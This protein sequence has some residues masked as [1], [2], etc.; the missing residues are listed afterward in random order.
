M[1]APEHAD[2][3]EVPSHPTHCVECPSAAEFACGARCQTGTC[4]QIAQ[5]CEFGG[6]SI[7]YAVGDCTPDGHGGCQR[8]T[9]DSPSARCSA[10][11]LDRARGVFALDER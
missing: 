6:H 5:E 9:S 8:S 7:Q 3:H 4:C 10:T 1:V 2:A 11:R